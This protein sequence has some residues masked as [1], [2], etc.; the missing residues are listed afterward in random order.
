MS[1]WESCKLDTKYQK[2]YAWVFGFSLIYIAAIL[3]ANVPYSDDW[4]R[5]VDGGSWNG[6]GRILQSWIS[7]IVHGHRT[8][9]DIS[10]WSQILAVAFF[11][12]G[13]VC[14][15]RNLMPEGTVIKSAIVA[16]FAYVNLFLLENVAFRYDSLGMMIGLGLVFFAYSFSDE[17]SV[18]W[19]GFFGVL[20]IWIVL[21]IYQ[22][23]VGAYLALAIVEVFVLVAERKGWNKI[24]K[25]LIA[26][27]LIMVIG[28]GLWKLSFIT[29][30]SGFLHGYAMDHAEI[31]NFATTSGMH[32]VYENV[33]RYKWMFKNYFTTIKWVE[34]MLM[35]SIYVALLRLVYTICSERGKSN[36]EKIGETLFVLVTPLLLIFAS[37]APL[38]LLK[39]PVFLPRVLMAFSVFT[40]FQG[41]ILYQ[42]SKCYSKIM[43][44]GLLSLVITLSHA[45]YF[46][47]LLSSQYR[48]NELVA[49][50]IVNDI[51]GVEKE[52]GRKFDKMTKVAGP[53]T[54]R[55]R[56][57]QLAVKKGK[58][59]YNDLVREAFGN[60]WRLVV[61]L[62]HYRTGK[63]MPTYKDDLDASRVRFKN[64]VRSNEFYKMYIVDDKIVVAFEKG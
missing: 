27:F 63:V 21:Y 41:Y 3:L 55:C 1:F 26:R 49:T 48:M 62:N 33:L 45:A 36:A 14:Y 60:H 37:I 56:E 64:P 13:L 24:K 11:D 7:Y 23:L 18:R 10:P 50:F 38:V 35:L 5:T 34:I 16:A 17:W 42:L 57:W 15:V 29:V 61:N 30:V 22:V 54:I 52:Y 39:H 44:I 20:T 25:S 8:L 6:D 58:P 9:M 46:G 32:T 40:F 19:K 53:N 51:N 2:V 43:A 31:V 12:Y 47:N 28:A 4:C 59:L